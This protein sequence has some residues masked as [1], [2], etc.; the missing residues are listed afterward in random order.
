MED[1]R[2]IYVITAR[3]TTD[4]MVDSMDPIA[5]REI[6]PAFQKL[7][8]LISE[9]IEE[10]GGVENIK[11]QGYEIDTNFYSNQRSNPV[12]WFCFREGEAASDFVEYLQNEIELR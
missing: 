3:W 5:F 9:E 11:A 7:S 8:N 4:G 1:S 12:A 2:K 6:E 10:R